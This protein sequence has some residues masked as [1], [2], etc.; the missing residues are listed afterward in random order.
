MDIL[1]VED[2]DGIAATLNLLLRRLDHDVRRV[3][4]GADAVTAPPADLMLLDLGLPDIDG[5]DVLAGIRAAGANTPVVIMTARDEP[6][7]RERALAAGADGFITKP[8]TIG[9]LIMAIDL[10]AIHAAR[11]TTPAGPPTQIGERASARPR[12]VAA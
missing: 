10:T 3:A 8:F 2:H 5:F 9:E 6:G 12:R 11:F 1:V 4:R 7:L